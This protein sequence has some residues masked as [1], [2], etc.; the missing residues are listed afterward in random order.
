[1]IDTDIVV[2]GAGP[3]GLFTVFEAGLLGMRCHLVDSLTKP[4]GQCAEIYPNKPIYDIPAYPEIMAGELIDKLLEQIKPFSPGYTLGETAEKLSKSEGKF[5]ITTD[6]NTQIS[7]KVIAIAGGLGNFE[8]RKPFIDDLN[9]FEDNGVQYSIVDPKKFH[10]KNVVISGGGDSALDW[11]IVLSEIANKVTLI[12][13]RNQFRGAVDSVNKIQQL[14]DKNKLDIITPAVLKKLNGKN[15]LESIDVAIDNEIINI[16]TDYLIPFYGLV[17][18]MD[19]FK[20]WGLEIE[21]NAIKVNNSLDYQT[22][23]EGIYAIGDINYYPG[24][25]KL[26]LSGFHEAAIMCHSA[27]QIINPGKKNILKYTTVSGISGFDGTKKEP[28]KTQ[29]NSFK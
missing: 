14:K 15:K 8:P 4:G 12:H 13:R 16:P 9:K 3:T 24:K 20:S 28:K 2:I 19:V 1:M 5:L 7:A 26:I 6:K 10:G 27:Y 11:T 21:K 23:K 17:P 22:N 29:I 18:K 25:L